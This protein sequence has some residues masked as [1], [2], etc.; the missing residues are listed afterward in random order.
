MRIVVAVWVVRIFCWFLLILGVALDLLT[1]YRNLRFIKNER[2]ASGIPVIPL[3]L[4]LLAG[5]GIR[6]DGATGFVVL[7]S[8]L[9]FHLSCQ[10]II[11][12]AYKALVR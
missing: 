9:I 2:G 10:Y 3:L 6:F 12:K 5:R 8:L 11:P 1:L 4:Y 7:G